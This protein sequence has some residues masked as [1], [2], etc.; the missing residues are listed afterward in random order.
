MV[1]PVPVLGL[2]ATVKEVVPAISML[3]VVASAM[4]VLLGIGFPFISATVKVSRSVA[5]QPERTTAAGPTKAFLPEKTISV[6]CLTWIVFWLLQ[7]PAELIRLG[8]SGSTVSLQRVVLNF[9]SAA[10]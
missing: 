2:F 8:F 1:V 5:V 4:V 3:P 9:P 6:Y 7:L 10:S